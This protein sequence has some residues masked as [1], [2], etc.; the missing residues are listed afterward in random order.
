[1]Q[2]IT[3]SRFRLAFA[4]LPKNQ[5]EAT[6]Q[7]YKQLKKDMAHPSLHFK[8]IRNNIYSARVSIKYRAL[9]VKQDDTYVWFWV[10]SHADYDQLIDSLK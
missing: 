10:G 6:R 2:S 5:Q 7:A 8:L 3:T 1:M 9:A 4:R